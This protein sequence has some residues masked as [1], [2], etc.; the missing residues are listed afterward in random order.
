MQ[1]HPGNLGAYSAKSHIEEHNQ[2][3]AQLPDEFYDEHRNL[4]AEKVL[5]R[6]EACGSSRDFLNF[7][8]S[9]G[10]RFPTTYALPVI[11]EQFIRWIDEKKDWEPP[12]NA[13]SNQRNNV[14]VIDTS[15]VMRLKDCRLGTRIY[16]RA[17]RSILG[18]KRTCSIPT[19]TRRR[20]S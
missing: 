9:L 19:E 6:T 3:L 18:P 20:R 5:A 4:M 2:A 10:I 11:M 16:L 14:W 15:N 1:L 17:G 7:L 8:D 13:D 12:L